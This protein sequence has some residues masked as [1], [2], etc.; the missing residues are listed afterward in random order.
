VPQVDG[1]PV[2]TASPDQIRSSIA[3]LRTGL[4]PR[5]LRCLGLVFAAGGAVGT[6]GITIAWGPF[7]NVWF[8]GLFGWWV[9][10]LMPAVMCGRRLR[11]NAQRARS[12]AAR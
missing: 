9:W 10:S 11:S 4:F 1:P 5:W 6:V 3:A 12:D 2:E 8:A 7:A